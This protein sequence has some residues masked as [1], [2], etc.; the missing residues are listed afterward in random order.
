M[1]KLKDYIDV[2]KQMKEICPVS[3]SGKETYGVSFFSDWDGDMVMY[4]KSTCTN[5]FGK[6]EFGI[7]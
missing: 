1:M 4:V 7:V 6:D 3:D 2:L 5:F